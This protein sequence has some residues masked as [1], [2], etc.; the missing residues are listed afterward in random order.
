MNKSTWCRL[1][2]AEKKMQKWTNQTSGPRQAG[3]RTIFPWILFSPWSNCVFLFQPMHVLPL[4][5][6]CWIQGNQK[7][8]SSLSQ[9][10]YH[11]W[12]AWFI[13]IN[14]LNRQYIIMSYIYINLSIMK[15]GTQF[16]HRNLYYLLQC[17]VYVKYQLVS[18]LIQTWY[19]LELYQ[20]FMYIYIFRYRIIFRSYTW[21]CLFLISCIHTWSS[22]YIY[23]DHVI[24]IY[25]YIL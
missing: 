25:I 11:I 18:S 5:W 15:N 4:S 10:W 3:K 16:T 7:P 1:V 19:Y 6:V 9:T 22:L 20:W 17:I 21:S 23:I 8:V 24:Y 14:Y 13:H 2:R 12:H